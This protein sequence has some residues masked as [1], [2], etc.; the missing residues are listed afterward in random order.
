MHVESKIEFG[1]RLQLLAD[2]FRAAIKSKTIDGY[3][4]VLQKYDNAAVWKA[5]DRAL[6]E[7]QRMPPPA[8][9]AA[10]ARE[11]PG[12]GRPADQI[13]YT[14]QVRRSSRCFCGGDKRSGDYVCAWCIDDLPRWAV[15]L[16][17]T[18]YPAYLDAVKAHILIKQ[19]ERIPEHG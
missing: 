18:P 12:D 17:A 1:R 14:A 3:W 5:M 10:Y 8:T 4:K 7:D 16:L 2:T 9:L 11:T 15:Q 19:Q 6:E 13:G